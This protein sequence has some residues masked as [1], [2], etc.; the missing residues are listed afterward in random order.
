MQEALEE[1]LAATNDRKLFIR[2][3]AKKGHPSF[4]EGAAGLRIEHDRKRR[5][6]IPIDVFARLEVPEIAHK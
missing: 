6:L 2:A 5:Y 3:D 4:P 1:L